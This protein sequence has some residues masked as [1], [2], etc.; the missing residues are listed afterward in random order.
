VRGVELAYRRG[1]IAAS[2]VGPAR[3]GPGAEHTWTRPRV[4]IKD[5]SGSTAGDVDALCNAQVHARSGNDG[6]RGAWVDCLRLGPSRPGGTGRSSTTVSVSHEAR[7][8]DLP[9]TDPALR[10]VNAGVWRGR[11]R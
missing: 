6:G 5:G 11:V 4:L 3:T 1:D 2:L 8:H 7:Q 9:V 10:P